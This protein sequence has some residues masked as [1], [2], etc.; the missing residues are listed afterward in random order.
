MKCLRVLNLKYLYF[1][2]P[3]TTTPPPPQQLTQ[4]AVVSLSPRVQFSILSDRSAV[5]IARRYRLYHFTS[6]GPLDQLGVL[7]CGAVAMAQL[8][9]IPCHIATNRLSQ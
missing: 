5:S 7:L 1:S 6:K 3:P 9:I 2:P 8:P 4:S